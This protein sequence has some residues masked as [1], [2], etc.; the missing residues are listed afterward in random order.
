MVID[1]AKQ[2][3]DAEDRPYR[4]HLAECVKIGTLF[5]QLRKLGGRR[6]ADLRQSLAARLV[7]FGANGAPGRSTGWPKPVV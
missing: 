2:A 5:G 4:M 1:G 6:A 7:Q 3:S